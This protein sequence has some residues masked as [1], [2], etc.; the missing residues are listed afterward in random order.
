MKNLI[1]IF[2][3]MFTLI[4]AKKMFENGSIDG[5]S[6][7]FQYLK[8]Y[9]VGKNLD[10]FDICSRE[11]LSLMKESMDKAHIDAKMKETTAKKHRLNEEKYRQKLREH[12]LDRHM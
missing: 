7:K 2:L 3:F 10:F 6:K 12:F 9:C 8:D 5:M 11:N 1:F 4:N